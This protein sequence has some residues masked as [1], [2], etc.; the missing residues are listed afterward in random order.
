MQISFSSAHITIHIK[1]ILTKG[2]QTFY[3][4]VHVT[5]T[6]A[7]KTI[8]RSKHAVKNNMNHRNLGPGENCLTGMAD[9]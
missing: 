7:E 9:Y 8:S 4:T 6:V 1:E 2:A 3:A 5:H